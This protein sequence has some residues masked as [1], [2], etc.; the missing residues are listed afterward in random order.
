MVQIE[1]AQLAVLTKKGKKSAFLEGKEIG[2]K[3]PVCSLRC[4]IV[5]SI[6]LASFN[7]AAR[8]DPLMTTPHRGRHRARLEVKSTE[9]KHEQ[10]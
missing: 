6:D 5:L 7:G 8:R 10:C 9:T 4:N 1:I 3:K 2:S